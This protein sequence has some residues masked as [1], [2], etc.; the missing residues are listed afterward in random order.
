M[1]A[2]SLC[3]RRSPA[4]SISALVMSVRAM[5]LAGNARLKT[6]DPKARESDYHLEEAKRDFAHITKIH[7]ERGWTNHAMFKN[8]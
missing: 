7:K 6:T 5:L 8:A 1:P 3:A 4:T 2:R